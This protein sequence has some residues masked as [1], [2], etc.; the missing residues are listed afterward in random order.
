M[1]GL[2]HGFSRC[3]NAEGECYIGNWKRLSE[4]SS[5]PSGKFTGYDKD[6]TM[7]QLDGSICQGGDLTTNYLIK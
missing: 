5:R 1:Q 3:I 6:G 2:F 7:K 4:N